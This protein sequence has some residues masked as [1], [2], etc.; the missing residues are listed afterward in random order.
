MHKHLH[1]H[2]WRDRVWINIC[3]WKEAKSKKASRT[4]TSVWLSSVDKN[5]CVMLMNT[6]LHRNEWNKCQSI[7]GDRHIWCRFANSVEQL[8]AITLPFLTIVHHSFAPPLAILRTVT[9]LCVTVCVCVCRYKAAFTLLC[10]TN[11]IGEALRACEMNERT[12]KEYSTLWF[13]FY[14]IELIN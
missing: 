9:L 6:V 4:H 11:C 2:S 10:D 12:S 13:V 7:H 14:G 5:M 8:C 3:E 1:I